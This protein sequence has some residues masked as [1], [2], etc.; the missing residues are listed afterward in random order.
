MTIYSNINPPREFYVYVYLRE[1]GTPYYIGKGSGNRAWNKGKGEVYPPTDISRIII[2]ESNLTNIG[3]LAIERRLIKWYGRL[4][5]G[6]GILRNKTDSGD[7]ASGAKRSDITK[8]KLRKPK[9]PGFGKTISNSLKG[10]KKSP[11]HIAN[12]LKSREGIFTNDVRKK[13]SLAH[14]GRIQTEEHKRK[15]AESNK[16][17]RWWNNGK[18]L[19]RAKICP[20]EGWVLGK[21][22]RTSTG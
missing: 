6:T 12:I 1:D 16:G 11:S 10:K 18:T 15:N 20:G 8:E 14:S 19:T 9:P 2:A 4:D 17:M 3:A 7:G 5:M 21:S 13:I 22:F